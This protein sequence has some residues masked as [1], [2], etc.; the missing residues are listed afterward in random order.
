L[1]V[2]L[3]RPYWLQRRYLRNTVVGFHQICDETAN[4]LIYIGKLC[5]KRR[6]SDSRMRACRRLCLRQFCSENIEWLIT[7]T[8]KEVPGAFGRLLSVARSVMSSQHTKGL[9]GERY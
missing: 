7:L 4:C 3:T 5:L 8:P 6:E 2:L 1:P 9:A